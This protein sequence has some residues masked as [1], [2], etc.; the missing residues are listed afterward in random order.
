MPKQNPNLGFSHFSVT[1]IR[2]LRGQKANPN[3]LLLTAILTSHSERHLRTAGLN[4]SKN[5]VWKKSE[6]QWIC[7]DNM[8]SGS[9]SP[10]PLSHENQIYLY[11]YIL[12]RCSHLFLTFTF[13]MKMFSPYN[14][15]R[16]VRHKAPRGIWW[17]T[18]KM[19][20][21]ISKTWH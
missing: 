21:S 18:R 13:L 19:M 4:V 1:H 15:F 14:H 6:R 5:A 8:H 11:I 3:S 10:W 12:I 7:S 20:N 16:N 2:A 9:L 17:I